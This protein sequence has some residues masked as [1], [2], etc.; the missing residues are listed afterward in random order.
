M[1]GG[2]SNISWFQ[3]FPEPHVAMMT[4]SLGGALVC[5]SKIHEVSPISGESAE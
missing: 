4:V 3:P 5:G 1:P 2:H